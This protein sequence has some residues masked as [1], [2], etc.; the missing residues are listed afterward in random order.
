MDKIV[1]YFLS[2]R[3]I[4]SMLV[5]VLCFV[6]WCMVR[7]A[8]RQ[9]LKK[10][11]RGNREDGRR[12]TYFRLGINGLKVVLAATALV[13][14]LQVHGVNVTSLVA[15]FGVVGVVVGLAMQD[16]LKDLIMG[17]NILSNGFFMVGDTV[18]YG[19]VRGV[20][21]DF[22]MRAT[23]IQDI[24]NGNILTVCNR[25]I[26][27]IIRLP[28]WRIVTVPAAYEDDQKQVRR[29]LEAACRDMEGQ[30]ELQ[31][32][33]LLGLSEFGDSAINYIIRLSAPAP[34]QAALRRVLLE[35]VRLRY[36]EEGL[37]IPYPQ[38]DVHVKE[39]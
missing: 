20:V 35:R 32:C 3:F 21:T 4:W 10:L 8:A 31:E 5:A 39:K 19:T 24:T 16:V 34:R 6:V 13:I 38:M 2:P 29:A 33:C 37:S 36:E 18:Q 9:Y 28:D 7:R 15:G 11:P 27:E 12:E 17:F 23:R 25:N 22:T 1:A 26:S 14:I 30:P